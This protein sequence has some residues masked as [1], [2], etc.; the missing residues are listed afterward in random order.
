MSAAGAWGEAG[1]GVERV[2]FRHLGVPEGLSQASALGIAQDAQG[3]VWIATQ[4][5]LDRYDG[6][7]FRIYQH[8]RGD[9]HS[10]VANNLRRLLLDRQGRLWAGATNGGLSRYDARLDR[11]D[12]FRPD[13]SRPGALGSGSVGALLQD[14]G[15]RVWVA[16]RGSGL[17]W[18]DEAAGQ[19][20]DSAC[21]GEALERLLALA[22]LD[23]GRLLLGGEG[24]LWLC[25]SAS[26]GLQEWR[27]AHGERLA[28][29][30]LAR[31]PAGGVWVASF[32]LGV[33]H[34]D[35]Q[36]RELDR[37]TPGA[38]PAAPDT[39]F[40]DVLVDHGGIVW[41]A[42]QS[43][44]LLRLDPRS[45]QLEV[46]RHD[47]ELPNSLA[48]NRVY[49]LFEDR[50]GLIWAGTWNNGASVFDPRAGG[51][52]SVRP[53]RAPPALPGAAVLAVLADPDGSFWFGLGDGGGLAH[54]DLQRGLL[55]SFRHDPQRPESLAHNF[56]MR[57]VRAADGSLWVATRGGGLDRLRPGAPGFEHFRHDPARVD[58]LAA[59]T[60]QSLYIDR[61]QTLWV[62]FLEDG[63]DALCAQ[64]SG[65]RH[66]G[67]GLAPTAGL[68]P[69][70][71]N[72]VL[73]R[74]DGSLWVGSGTS[75]LLRLDPASGHVEAYGNDPGDVGSLG[76]NVVSDLYEDSR[77]ELW[78]GTLGGGLN[79]LIERAGARPRFHAVGARDGLPSDSIGGIAED[80]R[81]RLWVST[82]V[83]ISRL[84]P[85]DGALVNYGAAQGASPAGYFITT[86]DQAPD[87]RIVFGGPAEATVLDP[88]ALHSVG[89][90]LPVIADLRLFNQPV[91]PRW[92]DAASPLEQAPWSGG[93]AVLDDR[94][95]MLTVSFGAPTAAAP[96]AVRFG[97]RLDPHDAD[98]IDTDASLRSATYTGLPAGEY[99]LR[100]RARYAGEPWGE[101]EASLS[102]KVL[103][104]PWW[105]PGAKLAYFGVLALLAVLAWQR[106]MA[107]RRRREAAQRAIRDS[108]ERLKLALWGSG[109][110]LW[111]IDLPSGAMHREN[112]L[113]HLAA[114]HE[115]GA[116]SMT[117]FRPFLHP[118]DLHGFERALARHLHGDTPAFEAAYR[119]RD[120]RQ[121]W[122]WILT[123]GRVV[124]RDD[125]G[126]AR[127]MSGTS[128]DI[129][130][131]K[132]AEEALRAL[133]EE[134]ESRVE[135]RTR[136]LQMAN[137]ELRGALERLRQAQRQ[138]L[139]AE[140]FASLGS[141]VAG[142]AHEINTPVGVGVTAASHLQEEARRLARSVAEG[143]LTR[144]ELE[145]FVRACSEGAE[146]ILRNLQRADRLVRSFKQ[147]AVD[148]ASEE[149]RRVDLGQCLAEI[150]TTLG[151]VLRRSGHRV[152]LQCAPGLALETAPGALAQIVTNLVMN[153]LQ[154]GFREG[155]SG[156]ARIDAAL[157]AGEVRLD[158]RD[159]GTGMD[160]A[161]RQRV[162]EPF[163]TTRR[164]QGGSGLGLPIVYN[165]VTQVLK[166]R[167]E[168]SS[169]PG[170]GVHFVLVWPAGD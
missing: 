83:G 108:E 139:E 169:G 1:T 122:V 47:P 93:Q 39:D 2:R 96:S 63:L 35:A 33:L 109:A 90:P 156:T 72:D 153:S 125:S 151:P 16:A 5:G 27:G 115:A 58:S 123:R 97:Y 78:V 161:V 88:E 158:Y 103:P 8:D 163:F 137:I 129:T 164:G 57:M 81:G 162:F 104:A 106:V 133:N 127:R 91:Y 77:G 86:V 28:V 87:G 114:T 148:Q 18:F 99:R 60:V 124:Q 98:W 37:Y 167:I 61:E 43:A 48:A 130:A 19:F 131:L 100:V 24:G 75:G 95:S 121:G 147:V 71:V 102:L 157:V 155:Q 56:V 105:S 44:G 128:S 11:F 54:F 168:C 138:L 145:R 170:A 111:D 92:R 21:R 165:L 112:R 62:G 32:G 101:Q 3:F 110:E 13:P 166:G 135:Q 45:R 73:E 142:V 41:A 67:H 7:G 140:K 134:L 69:G 36:G 9:T 107:Q 143:R 12:S 150:L 59:D 120:R 14:R 51:F 26:G 31:E 152:E 89:T 136:D 10:L 25:D 84:D 160:E 70:G 49:A 119:T 6:Y 68:P 22:E 126:H 52:V 65:F 38:D 40:N 149:R 66:Y 80:R 30:G 94:Q 79:R 113:E 116:A 76:A 159:D 42:S 15:G 117:A 50:D 154:H 46:F 23:D 118:D 53:G 64:C 141:L 4:D 55:R 29:H 85:R 144:S 82:T 74:R 34:L 20:R 146:L 132:Q 17:Q